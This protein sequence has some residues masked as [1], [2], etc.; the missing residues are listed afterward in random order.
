VLANVDEARKAT[1]GLRE[2]MARFGWASMAPRYDA[3][4]LELGGD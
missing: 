2:A 3:T 4:L 1:R